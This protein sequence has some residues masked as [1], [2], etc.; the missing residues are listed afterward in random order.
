MENT[1]WSCLTLSPFSWTWD[2]KSDVIAAVR[3]RGWVLGLHRWSFPM[4]SIK[5]RIMISFVITLHNSQSYQSIQAPNWK[6]IL[7][8]VT[9]WIT[10]RFCQS[11]RA[12]SSLV[13]QVCEE[14]GFQPFVETWW[15]SSVQSGWFKKNPPKHLKCDLSVLPTVCKEAEF[16]N[17]CPN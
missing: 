6:H 15:L 5:G 2:E 9:C 11:S 12:L 13:C 10:S 4:I 8:H 16:I 17:P 14:M 1:F 7:N 3:L